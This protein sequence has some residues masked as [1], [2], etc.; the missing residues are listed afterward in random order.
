MDGLIFDEK[1]MLDGNIFKYEKKLNSRLNRYTEN[2]MLLTTYLSLKEGETTVDR[3]LGEIEELFGKRSPLRYELIHDLPIMGFG[4]ANPENTEENGVPDINVDGEAIIITRTVIPRQYDCFIINHL[5]MRALFM[6]TGVTYDSMKVDGNYKISYHLQTTSEKVI[7]Q[8]LS[9]VV[10]EN[11][12]DLN[13]IGTDVNP[14]IRKDD[15]ILR[16]QIKQMVTKMIES[17]IAL[18]YNERHNCFLFYDQQTGMR[19]FDLCGNEFIARHSIMNTQNS[20][21]KIVLNDKIRDPLLGVYYNNSVYAW[22]ELDA[23]DR[24]LQKFSY[25]LSYGS[26]YMD[27]SFALW[28]EDDIMVMQP[29]SLQ[30][31]GVNIKDSFFDDEQFKSF[32]DKKHEPKSSEY[33]KLIWKFINKQDTLSIHDVSLYTADALISS[34]K[35]RDVFLYTPIIIY[36]IRKILLMN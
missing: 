5:K 22:L 7:N 20:S 8:A 28:D 26:G 31:A 33:D 19:Y 24:L 6:V 1:T 10:D 25:M 4:A 12:T 30:Q 35:H 9:Q 29:L 13:A 32:M 18:F 14:I 16:N 36:I 21:R 15:F 23:P 2:G 11:Y 17:Y 34:V 27:S 3:G